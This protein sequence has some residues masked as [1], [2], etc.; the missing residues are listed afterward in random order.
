M[1]MPA[2]NRAPSTSKKFLYGFIIDDIIYL[3]QVVIGPRSP[4][5]KNEFDELVEAYEPEASF[6][7]SES[8]VLK[9]QEELESLSEET[10]GL[11]KDLI[12]LV[13]IE[14]LTDETLDLVLGTGDYKDLEEVEVEE[15]E[16]EE[17]LED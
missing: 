16:E 13:V 9:F 2:H 15:I 14:G 4:A 12:G 11:V 7:I 1:I 5:W 17:E 3:E 6:V 10:Y 8:G